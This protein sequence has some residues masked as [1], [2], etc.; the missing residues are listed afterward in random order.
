MSGYVATTANDLPIVSHGPSEPIMA[1]KRD[2]RLVG[3]EIS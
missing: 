2:L 1:A 3:V